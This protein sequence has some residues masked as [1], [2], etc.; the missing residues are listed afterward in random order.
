M[1]TT[2]S[3]HTTP[4]PWE[5]R[6]GQR[7]TFIVQ[8]HQFIES[9][10]YVAEVSPQAAGA[11]GRPIPEQRAADARM[12]S[13]TP[14]LAKALRDLYICFGDREGES[15]WWEEWADIPGIDTCE[16]RRICLDKAR[17]ALEK[18]GVC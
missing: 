2:P 7:T 12:I 11:D 3:V 1:K 16:V 8:P 6:T 15:E 9:G 17:A 4:G 18:A 13:A 5:V 10:V 14:D